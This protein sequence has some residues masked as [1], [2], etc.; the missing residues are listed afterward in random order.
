[1]NSLLFYGFEGVE[2]AIAN[3]G[4]FFDVNGM[5]GDVKDGELDLIALFDLTG[6]T[7]D[8]AGQEMFQRTAGFKTQPGDDERTIKTGGRPG[9]GLGDDD[10]PGFLREVD[11]LQIIGPAF[12]ADNSRREGDVAAFL[13]FGAGEAA[14][15]QIIIKRIKAI[16]FLALQRPLIHL[17]DVFAFKSRGSYDLA[18]FQF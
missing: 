13:A 2:D 3:F 9:Q 15:P 17:S 5:R 11:P 12:G 10:D 6:L 18:R 7:I 14:G 8:D 4:F 1:M 16:K